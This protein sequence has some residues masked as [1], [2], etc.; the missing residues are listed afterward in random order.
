MCRGGFT[1]PAGSHGE[2][3]FS[4]WVFPP[5][6]IRHFLRYLP[7]NLAEDDVNAAEAGDQVAEHAALGHLGQR[8]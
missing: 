7:V 5:L 8:L 1:P 4:P 3:P 2:R 6:P